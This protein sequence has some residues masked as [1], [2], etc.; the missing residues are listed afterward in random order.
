M[1]RRQTT[2]S[3]KAYMTTTETHT[4]NSSLTQNRG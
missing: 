4:S 3:S 2:F 1:R